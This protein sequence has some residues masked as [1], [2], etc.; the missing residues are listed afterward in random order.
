MPGIFIS[1]RREDSSAYASRLYDRLSNHFGK[2]NVFMDIDSIEPGFDFIEVLER[3]ISMCDT[4][5]VVIGKQ[6]LGVT[7]ADGRR[8][9]DI[10]E[11][12][13]WKSRRRSRERFESCR[14][15]SGA[16]ASFG[17]NNNPSQY[18]CCSGLV[19]SQ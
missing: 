14:R 4:V 17:K 18:S 8:R 19:V 11:E 10:P 1:Y 2:D 7:D 6:W 13:G 16:H 12:C 3:T 5:I 15:L 9:L